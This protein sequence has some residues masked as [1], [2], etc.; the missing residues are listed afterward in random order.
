MASNEIMSAVGLV[1]ESAESSSAGAEESQK[2]AS[3]LAGL[4]TNLQEL[5]ARFTV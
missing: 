2:A 3:E 4:A 1:A 5:M